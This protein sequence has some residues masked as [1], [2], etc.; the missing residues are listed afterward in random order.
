MA[1][2]GLIGKLVGG[3]KEADRAPAPKAQPTSVSRAA[4]PASRTVEYVE[5][6]EVCGA[7]FTVTGVKPQAGG[8]LVRVRI[9]ITNSGQRGTLD[10]GRT[11][12]FLYALDRSIADRFAAN[13]PEQSASGTARAFL[14][15]MNP[16]RLTFVAFESAE[17]V[18]MP[19]SN[20]VLNGGQSVESWLLYRGDIPSDAV[21]FVVSISGIGSEI[22]PGGW[23]SY[24]SGQPFISLPAK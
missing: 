19:A 17:N 5:N 16:R 12:G 13:Y 24:Q 8:G 7:S 10:F 20:L 21:A 23:L 18:R 2:S 15:G 6:C 1:N 9:K 14:T 3:S 4:A 22:G 11:T